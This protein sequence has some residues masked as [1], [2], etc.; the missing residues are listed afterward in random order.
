M[1]GQ[2][3]LPSALMLLLQTDLYIT[4]YSIYRLLHLNH[5]LHNCLTVSV[6]PGPCRLS[7]MSP[8]RAMPVDARAPKRAAPACSKHSV[9]AG[10]VRFALL[11]KLAFRL[12]SAAREQP[13]LHLKV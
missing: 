8:T 10:C 5:F 12:C 1:K 3:L 6:M 2:L 13:V 7:R 4:T 9:Q 11:I